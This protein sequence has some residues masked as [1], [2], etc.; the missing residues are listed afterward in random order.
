MDDPDRAAAWQ[1]LY[2]V[3]PRGWAVMSPQWREVDHLWAV[4]ARRVAGGRQN[5]GRWHEA[6]GQTEAVA[7]RALAQQFR[8]LQT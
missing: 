7:L 6:F 2:A 8:N 4:Y 5:G 3:L 1:E